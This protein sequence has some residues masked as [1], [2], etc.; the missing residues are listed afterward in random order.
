MPRFERHFTL[1][2]A[3][4]LIPDLRDLLAKIHLLI[5]TVEAEAVGY[6]RP[7]LGGNGDRIGESLDLP[8]P[9]GDPE[10]FVWT[11]RREQKEA[12]LKALVGRI[13]DQGIVIQDLQ[14]GLIDFPAWKDGREILLCYELDDG[15]AIAYWHE[16]EAGYAGR[17]AIEE[18]DF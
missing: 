3:Q 11:L 4:A 9:G 16:L 1:A 17:Q 12:L 14:R 18:G 8:G 2:E 10:G 13:V 7:R 15:D 5:R 6:Q